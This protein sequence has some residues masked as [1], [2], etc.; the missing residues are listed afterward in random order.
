M[1]CPYCEG[2]RKS[3]SVL[4]TR[5]PDPGEVRRRR[6]CASCGERF[7][8][9]ER[10]SAHDTP[11]IKRGDRPAEKFSRTKLRNG[12]MKAA[13]NWT[14]ADG[15]LDSIVERVVKR[16][17]PNPSSP[18][19][20]AEIGN[21]VLRVLEGGRP[22]TAITRIRY[23]MVLLGRTSRTTQFKGLRDFIAW[24]EAEYGTP[25]VQRPPST[26]VVV[27]K[28]DGQVRNFNLRRLERS[29]GIASKGR[30][31]DEEVKSLASAIATRTVSELQGQAIVTSQQIAAEVLKAL[32]QRDPLA[33]LRYGSAVKHYGSVD[34]FWLDAL[35]LLDTGG[36]S[37][38]DVSRA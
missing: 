31:T 21:I 5:T 32:K 28:R 19:S 23:A 14:L 15:E 36:T 38:S 13:A 33:Y 9:V 20:S 10:I 25:A 3:V 18:V 27:I 22:A 8:T 26:P 34:D 24:L 2:P 11:V 16:L 30:G 12:I 29:I 6:A 4:S 35:A 7:E 17:H 1:D 37:R